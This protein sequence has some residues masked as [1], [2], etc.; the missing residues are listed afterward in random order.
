MA[1]LNLEVGL[2]SLLII[3]FFIIISNFFRFSWIWEINLWIHDFYGLKCLIG[4]LIFWVNM[5]LL[6]S[7]SK[8]RILKRSKKLFIFI[9]LLAVIIVEF[10]LTCNL[11]VIYF[12]FELSLIPIFLIILGWGYQVERFKARIIILFYTLFA[13]LPLLLSLIYLETRNKRRLIVL[14]LSFNLDF[15]YFF[16]F[17]FMVML[18]FLVKTPVFLTHSWL[19][20]AHVEAPVFGSMRL[21]ALLLK[22]GTYGVYLFSLMRCCQFTFL[23]IRISIMSLF[24]VR[25]VCLRVMDTKIIIALSSVS[26]IGLILAGLLIQ[27]LELKLGRI[28]LMLA[29]GVSSRLLFFG[30][31]LVYE[32]CHSRMLVL[33]KGVIRWIPIF[34]LFWFLSIMLNMASPPRINLLREIILIINFVNYRRGLRI[35]IFLGLLIGTGYSLLMYRRLVQGWEGRFHA[36]SE[37]RIREKRVFWGY[38]I[39]GYLRLAVFYNLI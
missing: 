39:L 5:I 29:H 11:F 3:L 28:Y 22:L 8:E 2:S 32:R 24:T 1:V 18:A 26:H 13:R 37:I 17:I 30:A 7:L 36:K 25:L 21:A 38:L 27:R 31:G 16:L 23:V 14:I 6:V 10:F 34:G 15:N 12:I 35:W 20:K 19:P 4:F 33:R 9:V